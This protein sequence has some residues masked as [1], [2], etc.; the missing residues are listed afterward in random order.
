M[1]DPTEIEVL[2]AC[3][4]HGEPVEKGEIVEV[5]TATARSLIGMGKARA[6]IQ[7][8]APVPQNQDPA[9]QNRDPKPSDA[10]DKA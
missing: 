1:E 3:G 7:T 6:Y 4:I 10:G 2:E 8:Q 9:P 5:D